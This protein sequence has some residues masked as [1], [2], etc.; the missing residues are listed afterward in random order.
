MTDGLGERR[1]RIPRLLAGGPDPID[2]DGDDWLEQL[3]RRYPDPDRAAGS[4]RPAVTERTRSVGL[5]G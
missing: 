4:P 2:L 3:E 1:V 5:A